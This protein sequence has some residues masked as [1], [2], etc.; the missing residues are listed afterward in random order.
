MDARNND[1]HLLVE[2]AEA[3][4]S[5]RPSDV[6]RVARAGKAAFALSALDEQ[7][8]FAELVY[9]SLS[10]QE[11]SLARADRVVTRTLTFE[12]E[13][14]SI[15][16]EVDGDRIVGQIVPPKAGSVTAEFRDEQCATA[17]TDPL[18]CFTLPCPRAGEFRLH[19]RAGSWALLTEWTRIPPP[20]SDAS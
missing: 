6:A 9:D 13:G 20:A 14:C 1:E 4:R 11:P 19:V 15:V 12:S 10:D 16:L 17:V 5:L 3:H 8:K 2:L 18:G 7:L